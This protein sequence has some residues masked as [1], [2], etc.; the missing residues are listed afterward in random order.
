MWSRITR[1]FVIFSK[2]T[3]ILRLEHFT[4]EFRLHIQLVHALNQTTDVM[5]EYLA[6]RLVDLRGFRFASQAVSKLRFDHAE[7]GFNVAP[8]V[9]LLE[10]PL[11]VEFVIVI[12]LPPKVTL[13]LPLRFFVLSPLS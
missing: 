6:E 9:V 4:P 3:T 2:P 8:L 1:D 10:E 13:T 12:H 7:R 11:L 5:T